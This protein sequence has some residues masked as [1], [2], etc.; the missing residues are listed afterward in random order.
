MKIVVL[1]G[2]TLNPGDLS[3]DA[4]AHFGECEVYERTPPDE[5]LQRARGADIALTNKVI[6]GRYEIENLPD[7]RYVGVCATGYNVVDVQ[8]ARERQ[9]PVTNVPD[10]ATQSVA[11]MVFALLLELTN[12]VGHHDRTVREGRW[13]A[14]PDFCYWDY[15]LIELEG[16]TMGIVG[17]GR[18]GQAVAH[19]A[20]AFGMK[21]LGYDVDPAKSALPGI[22]CVD[23]DALFARSDVVSLHCL[24][25]PETEELVDAGRLSHMKESALL[26]N[27]SRGGLVNERDL[28]DA[29]SSGGIG[30]AAVDVLSSEPPSADNVLLRAKN[31][32]VT[33]HIAWASRSARMRLMATVVDNVRAFL[34]GRSRNVVN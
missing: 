30:G 12:H 15:P 22:E 10:Y 3:W 6:L 21:V 9:I 18:I 23:L 33:P 7:L 28:A 27:T 5:V 17:L 8:A 29:L 13:G 4:L 34:D 19:L 25:T 14:C 1:D 31:C 2:H 16:M 32:Y 20:A 11:Q 24:L 26:I